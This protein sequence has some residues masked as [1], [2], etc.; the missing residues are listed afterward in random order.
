MFDGKVLAVQWLGLSAF[1]AKGPGPVPGWET[2]ILQAVEH[3]SPQTQKMRM[4]H[5]MDYYSAIKKNEILLF[6]TTWMDLGT[7]IL[8]EVSQTEKDKYHM[9]LLICGI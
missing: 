3:S 9:I 4:V 5:T 7:L 1:T 6:A 8:S 2:K